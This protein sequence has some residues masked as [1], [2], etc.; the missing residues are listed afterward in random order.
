MDEMILYENERKGVKSTGFEVRVTLGAELDLRQLGTI[1]R[2]RR[3]VLGVA[4]PNR[5]SCPRVSVPVANNMA[6][7]CI[8]PSIYCVSK[9]SEAPYFYK[10]QSLTLCR[11]ANGENMFRMLTMAVLERRNE[12]TAPA[13]S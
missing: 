12:P 13:I 8:L 9:S 10:E 5:R 1:D 11:R 6:T 2:P 4:L 7:D 3:G